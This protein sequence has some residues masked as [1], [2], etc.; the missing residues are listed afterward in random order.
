MESKED[1]FKNYENTIKDIN[2]SIRYAEK[3]LDIIHSGG[4]FYDVI[5]DNEGYKT[6]YYTAFKELGLSVDDMIGGNYD[7]LEKQLILK[8]N[9]LKN[10]I[11]NAANARPICCL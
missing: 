7:T 11:E 8:I 5:Y 9:L 10:Q 4:D 2:N 3:A 1:I 6:S